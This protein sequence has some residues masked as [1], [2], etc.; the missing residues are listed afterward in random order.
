MDKSTLE[1]IFLSASI[2]VQG[3]HDERYINTADVIAIRD[4]VIAFASAIL[5]KFHLVWGGHP[6]ITPLIVNVVKHYGININENITLY[7]SRQ[8]EGLFPVENNS[9]GNIILTAKGDNANE[10]LYIMRHQMLSNHKYVAGVFIGGMNGV[11]DE[12]NMFKDLQ[13]NAQLIPVASTGA[14]AKIIYEREKVELMFSDRL[15]SDLAYFSLFKDLLG[16]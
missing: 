1:C 15:E 2:P 3:R 16:I 9:I 12:Y 4:A 11:E 14:A 5:P 7:Q 10:S 13:P 8:Y 6:S